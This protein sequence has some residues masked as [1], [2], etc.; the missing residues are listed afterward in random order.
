[1][2]KVHKLPFSY[3]GHSVVVVVVMMVERWKKTNKQNRL[4][5]QTDSRSQTEIWPL[6]FHP[7]G[8]C[9]CCCCFCSRRP[10]TGGGGGWNYFGDEEV[11]HNN[12]EDS[13][14]H[15]DSA[16]VV[17]AGVYFREILG[18]VLLL[19]L[20]QTKT[21]LFWPLL[22]FSNWNGESKGDTQTHTHTRSLSF[23]AL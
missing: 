18:R 14:R 15:I 6:L 7:R 5:V 17:V 8:D 22:S 13:V 4:D 11:K 19:L 20:F 23:S 12:D 2:I 16:D 3:C 1:M 21:Y 10:I 9:C